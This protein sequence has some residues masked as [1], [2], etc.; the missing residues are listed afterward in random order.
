MWDHAASSHPELIGVDAASIFSMQVVKQH[1][2]ALS[3]QIGEAVSIRYTKRQGILVMNRKDEYNRCLIPS[4]EVSGGKKPPMK[5][6]DKKV[7]CKPRVERV[8]EPRVD[9][10][11]EREKEKF[12]EKEKRDNEEKTRAL[13]TENNWK[14]LERL[15][16]EKNHQTTKKKKSKELNSV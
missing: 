4:L 6:V 10:L 13:K 15:T 14:Y 16:R 5:D 8:I 3:R 12:E 1:Q 11:I 7:D 2:S 9:R